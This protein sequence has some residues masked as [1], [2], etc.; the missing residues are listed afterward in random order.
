M[1]KLLLFTLIFFLSYLAYAENKPIKFFN[2]KTSEL[3]TLLYQTEDGDDSIQVDN[4]E[5][6]SDNDETWFRIVGTYDSSPEWIDKLTIE[7]YVQ[8][9]PIETEPLLFKG[10]VTC[11]D[12]PRGRNHRCAMYMHFNTYKRY[13]KRG[14]VRYAVIARI[15]GKEIAVETNNKKTDWWKGS[16]IIPNKLLNRNRTPFSVLNMEEHENEIAGQP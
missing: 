14:K 5:I 6:V 10:S 3:R 2:V 9:P 15:N 11:V 12:I 16:P 7:F 1:K 4:V 13:Y 8:F